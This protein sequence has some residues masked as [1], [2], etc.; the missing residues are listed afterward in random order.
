M[1]YLII[2]RIIQV[3]N[4]AFYQILTTSEFAEMVESSEHVVFFQQPKK[5]PSRTT[6]SPIMV[7]THSMP[8][9]NLLKAPS[10]SKY[11]YVKVSAT[12]LLENIGS[13]SGT[14]LNCCFM[15]V[16]VIIKM[17]GTDRV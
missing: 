16:Q 6:R 5:N 8:S 4:D 7:K 9:L 12:R 13:E 10:I 11:P 14:P 1:M 17:M 2:L 15:S 3:F